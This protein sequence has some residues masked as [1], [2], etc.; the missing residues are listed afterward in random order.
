MQSV[1]ARI[2][3][4]RLTIVM[5]MDSAFVKKVLEANSVTDARPD[6]TNILSVSVSVT[7]F[8]QEFTSPSL[9]EYTLVCDDLFKRER[10]VGW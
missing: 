3:V 1:A 9:L 4:L 10:N 5:R 2:Q 8:I 7:L 6:S